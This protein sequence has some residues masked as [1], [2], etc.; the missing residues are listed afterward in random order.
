M[1]ITIVMNENFPCPQLLV[2]TGHLPL[3]FLWV[4]L[5]KSL[6]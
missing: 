5:S 2:S 6:K 1:E 4:V 3:S